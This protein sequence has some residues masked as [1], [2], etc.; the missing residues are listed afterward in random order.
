MLPHTVI[1]ATALNPTAPLYQ[2]L[3]LSGS[4]SPMPLSPLALSAM[5]PN[6]LNAN[7]IQSNL[8]IVNPL[9]PVI[10]SA[11]YYPSYMSYQDVNYDRNLIDQITTYY[12]NKIIDN[13]MRNY[14]AD[15]YKLVTVSNGTASLIKNPKQYDT[16]TSTSDNAIKYEYIMDHYLAKRDVCFLLNKFRKLN[17]LNWWDL[18]EHNDKIKKYIRHR[19]I[20]QMIKHIEK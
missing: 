6:G 17:N 15:L 20:K 4:L 3:S 11:P 14:F 9:N 8:S 5:Y 19:V 1:S 2:P 12:Y 10:S 16:S 18:K 7:L 13:W